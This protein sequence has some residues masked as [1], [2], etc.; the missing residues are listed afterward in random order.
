MSKLVYDTDLLRII[1][2]FEDTTRVPVKDCFYFNDKLLFVVNQGFLFKALGKN[3]VNAIKLESLLNRKIKIVEFNP[4]LQTFIY[5]L[6]YPLQ[7]TKIV[8]EDG[9]V[10]IE[11][12]DTKT[13]G[14]LIG[15]HAKNLRFYESVVKKYFPHIKELRV[16]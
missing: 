6:V 13:K 3:G 8:E 2:V 10:T 5:N 9:V 4:V 12:K 16:V 15:Y 14:L 1:K 11:G 7:L